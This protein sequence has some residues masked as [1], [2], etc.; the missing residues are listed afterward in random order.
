MVRVFKLAILVVTITLLTGCVSRYSTSRYG[1][2]VVLNDNESKESVVTQVANARFVGQADQI[3]YGMRMKTYVYELGKDWIVIGT[4]DKD[5]YLRSSM[6]RMSQDPELVEVLGIEQ[7]DL[8][9]RNLPSIDR[10]KG[11]GCALGLSS[12]STLN[13]KV[14][15]AIYVDNTL[16]NLQMCKEVE[17]IEGF[18]ALYP[19][20]AEQFVAKA[21]EAIKI[22]Q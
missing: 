13:D 19:D 12:I 1:N 5:D 2:K 8:S 16:L 14:L 3:V 6:H 7:S 10:L 22:T 18:Y 21:S 15:L 20:M 17:D 11:G 4:V 9:V